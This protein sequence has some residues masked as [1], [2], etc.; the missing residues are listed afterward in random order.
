M[1]KTLIIIFTTIFVTGFSCKQNDQKIS[2]FKDID[3]FTLNGKNELLYNELNYPHIRVDSLPTGEKKVTYF[4]SAE[5]SKSVTYKKT[6]LGWVSILHVDDP[7]VYITKYEIVP[8]NGTVMFL[9]YG[10]NTDPLDTM[11]LKV[12]DSMVLI[13]ARI[14]TESTDNLYTFG[15]AKKIHCELTADTSEYVKAMAF[16][17]FKSKHAIVDGKMNVIFNDCVHN[18]NPLLR[19][20]SQGEN[21]YEVGY[22]S[23]AWVERYLHKMDTCR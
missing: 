21:C 5:D 15:V 6:A 7:L 9:Q 12:S 10:Q 18:D 8:V 4:Y 20:C 3:I 14:V 11:L 22:F 2:F 16:G 23:L 17:M 13:S 1:H 19:K